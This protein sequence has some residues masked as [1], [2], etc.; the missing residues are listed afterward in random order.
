MNLPTIPDEPAALPPPPKHV[1]IEFQLTRGKSVTPVG[2]VKQ[3]FQ[4]DGANGYTLSSV[5]EASGLVSLFVSGKFEER[6][7]GV[8]TDRGLQPQHY[9][10]QRGNGKSQAAT[11]DWNTHTVALE[12]GDR[13]SSADMPED[14]QD[15]LSFLYQFM[16]VPPLQQMRITLAN[17]R[18]V[19][20]YVYAFEGEQDLDTRIGRVHAL[21]ISKSSGDADEKLEAW[22]AP[23]YRYLPVKIRQ[24][25]KDGTVTEQLV[26][27]LQ[28][29]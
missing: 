14:T 5:A 21:H 19:K 17:G 7:V 27:R 15:M 16:F 28:I 13:K 8:I 3:V 26:T 29:Q 10:Q 25:D 9:S 23:D 1:E 18:K 2:K 11:F 24:T 12:A 4:I 20:T 22:L 6:S